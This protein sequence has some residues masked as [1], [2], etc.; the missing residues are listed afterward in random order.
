MRILITTYHE[1]FLHKGG[2]EFEI[3]T[4][5]NVLQRFGIVADIYGP[6]CQNLENYDLVIHFSVHTG[7]LEL[8]K[9]IKKI[10]IPIILIPN[11]YTNDNF[12]DFELVN[13]FLDLSNIVLFNSNAMKDHFLNLFKCDNSKIRVV[14]YLIDNR[15]LKEVNGDIFKKLY[16]ID[17]YALSFGIIE[18]NK[19]QLQTIEVLNQL[20]IKLVIVGKYRSKEYYDLCKQIAK[21]VLFIESLA[22]H[23]D[24]MLSALNGC[25]FY[26]ELSK[27]PAGLSAIEA[28]ICGSKV[29]VND[30]DWGREILND[31]VEFIDINKSNNDIVLSINDFLKRSKEEK[32]ANKKLLKH[33]SDNSIHDLIE[34]FK[35]CKNMKNKE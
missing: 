35:Y 15:I 29:I 27:E 19:N 1:A 31:N 3:I 21:N 17:K 9:S 11:F 6:D 10:N 34:I 2:G 12:N 26:I 33:L 16:N 24:I 7:G 32:V 5:A 18:E 13:S 14:N 23:S 28:A 4:L 22:Y 30:T 25:E 8:L 20:G